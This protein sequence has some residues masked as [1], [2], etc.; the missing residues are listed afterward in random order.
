[1]HIYKQLRDY[2][3]A[4]KKEICEG[5]VAEELPVMFNTLVSTMT[6]TLDRL[7]ASSEVVHK[8]VEEGKEGLQSVAAVTE[9]DEVKPHSQPDA[10]SAVDGAVPSTPSCPAPDSAALVCAPS[11]RS[12]PTITPST[13]PYCAMR[14]GLETVRHTDMM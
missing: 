12:P 13:N 2:Q 4:M 7:S 9:N 5:S 6:E 14:A 1:V 8:A 11:V 3:K 10:H